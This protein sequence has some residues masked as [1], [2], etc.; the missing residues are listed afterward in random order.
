MKNLVCFIC[1][2][3][4]RLTLIESNGKLQVR[5]NGCPRGIEFAQKEIY[6]PERTL[7]STV[8]VLGGVLPLVSVR[9]DIPVKKDELIGIVKQ[10]DG[11]VIPA[12]VTSGQV[13]LKNA[14]KNKA[15]IIATRSIAAV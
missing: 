3:S 15:T 11:I 2:N 4:C 7:T 6:D 5:H 10:L 12:P 9:S 14:G 13:V 1:P 8:K